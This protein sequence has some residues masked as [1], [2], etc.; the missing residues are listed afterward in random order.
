MQSDPAVFHDVLLIATNKTGVVGALN[1]TV[2]GALTYPLYLLHQM[3]G[4]MIFNIAYPVINP[5]VLLWSTIAVMIGL[6]YL[7]HK[8]IETPMARVI[9][10]S[11]RFPSPVSEADQRISND[12][13]FSRRWPPGCAALARFRVSLG[14]SLNSAR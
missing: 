13:T 9:K 8:E 7:I 12:A 5:H 1:W 10:N 14:N 2:L 11:S 6:S 4:F 3:I